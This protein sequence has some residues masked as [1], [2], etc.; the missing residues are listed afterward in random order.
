MGFG[1]Y[2]KKKQRERK[3]RQ[4]VEDEAFRKLNDL[5]DRFFIPDF[6]KFFENVLG[7][8]PEVE[9]E[10][11]DRTEKDVR[12]DPSRK[13][14]LDFIYDKIDT[15]ETNYKQI[16]DFAIRKKVIPPSFFGD[17]SDI[18]GDANEFENIINTIRRGFQ[19][20]KFIFIS[21]NLYHIR[22]LTTDYEL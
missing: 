16:K 2:I 4:R 15:G 3:E 11:D 14:Y 7:A 10:Y 20:E 19:P 6:D 5:L 13:N 18:V 12:K 9:Y 17:D 22:N 8:K 21:L 1:D